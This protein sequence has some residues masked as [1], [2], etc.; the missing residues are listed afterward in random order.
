M[1]LKQITKKNGNDS[2][3]ALETFHCW[4][5]IPSP[6]TAQQLSISVHFSRFSHF[7]SHSKTD[8]YILGTSF[9][10]QK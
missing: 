6:K 8:Q 4:S 3:K 2:S 1:I 7:T 10:L 9:D 5:I